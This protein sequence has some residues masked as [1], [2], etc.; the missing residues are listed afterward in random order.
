MRAYEQTIADVNA[1]EVARWPRGAAF[2]VHPSMQAIT[3][4]VIMRA[5]FGVSDPARLDALRESLVAVLTESGSPAAIGLLIDPVRRLPRFRRFL[6]NVTRA[7]ELLYA[8]IAERRAD[9]DLSERA[10]ILSMMV[11]AE[12]DDGSQMSDAELRDQLMTLLLAGHETTATALAFTLHLL[13][14]HPEVQQRVRAEAE[15]VLGADE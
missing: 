1:A 13:G 12:F 5:V 11:A 14:C 9:P 8:E 6:A 10:D 2:A 3:L 15:R 4:E 7:D